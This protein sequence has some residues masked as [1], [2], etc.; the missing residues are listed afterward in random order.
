MLTENNYALAGLNGCPTSLFEHNI[1]F[2]SSKI[3]CG[4]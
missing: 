2:L 4:I 1:Y 3:K